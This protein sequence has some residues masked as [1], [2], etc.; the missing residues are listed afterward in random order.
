MMY[1]LSLIQAL[2]KRLT[3]DERLRFMA[4][5]AWNTLIGYLLFVAVHFLAGER[6]GPNWTLV[7]SYCLA[8]PHSFVT[9]RLL[10]FGNSGPWR[11]QLPKFA[12]ANSV[13]FVSNLVLLSLA[14]T[15]LTTN[16]ALVQGVL[17]ALLTVASYLAHKYFSFASSS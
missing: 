3:G 6:I 16:V 1:R 10:V 5:G 13:I 17:V 8:L 12:A 11:R 9:Q 15:Y 7:L 2:C 14:S 4:V